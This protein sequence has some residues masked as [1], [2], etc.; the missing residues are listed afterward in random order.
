MHPTRVC[1][2]NLYST[3]GLRSNAAPNTLVLLI[4]V[5]HNIRFLFLVVD[6]HEIMKNIRSPIKSVLLLFMTNSMDD[7][8][9]RTPLPNRLKKTV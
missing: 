3:F 9:V 6:L 4:H 8:F 2:F 1:P 5:A 7:T